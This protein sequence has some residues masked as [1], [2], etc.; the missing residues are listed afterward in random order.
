MRRLILAAL[1]SLAPLPA[2]GAS[3]AGVP[4]VDHNCEA[5]FKADPDAHTTGCL[6]QCA[7]SGSGILDG[8][9]WLKLDREGNEKALSA[10]KH[11]SL[12]DHI[13]VNV[14]G[15][16]KGDLVHVKTLEIAS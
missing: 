14:T 5:K 2:L 16:R 6:V 3:W 9:T 1:V 4:L 13:R 15:D 11:T 12:K 7:K 10:L 8:K